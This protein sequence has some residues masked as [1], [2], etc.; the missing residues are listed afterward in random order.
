[1][2]FVNTKSPCVIINR[3]YGFIQFEL[4]L[5]KSVKNLS[6]LKMFFTNNCLKGI[7]T[8]LIKL[9][10]LESYYKTDAKE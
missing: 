7:K 10:R 4:Y 6:Y 2:G 9:R 3:F 5:G 8:C 1:M